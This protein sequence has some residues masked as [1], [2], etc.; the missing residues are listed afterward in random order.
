MKKIFVMKKINFL[1]VALSFITL[2]SCHT[3]LQV[4]QNPLKTVSGY[5]EEKM[6]FIGF[7]NLNKNN[8]FAKNY[9]QELERARIATNK[10]DYYMGIYSL[11]EL[12]AYKSTKRYVA[13]VDVVKQ[14]YSYN[15][16]IE[17]KDGLAIGGWFI[18]GFTCFTL[19]PV[20]LPM[21]CCADKDVCQI[22]LNGSY[23]LYVYDTENK[24]VALTLPMEINVQE[25]Y[26][27]QY[28]HKETNKQAV[29][30]R[31]R[32][33]LFNLWNEYFEKAYRF[34]EDNNK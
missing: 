14:Q 18:A 25:R 23:V 26:K 34:I 9:G 24:E 17:D 7:K 29:Q 30:E 20:Y 32:N 27:G 31:Y 22:T 33:M 13:F 5:T 11:Q 19:F 28:L 4:A 16:A 15:D 6:E 8:L 1:L 12:A 10:Q 21:I 3:A 2:T